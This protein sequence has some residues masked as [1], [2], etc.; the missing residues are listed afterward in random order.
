VLF[1][2]P[3]GPTRP[4]EFA[5]R[6]VHAHAVRSRGVLAEAGRAFQ[7]ADAIG[8]IDP[9]DKGSATLDSSKDLDSA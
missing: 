9:C 1:P 5:R 3:L 8:S 6:I 7:L 4:H 2:A